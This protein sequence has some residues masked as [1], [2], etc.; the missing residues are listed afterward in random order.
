MALGIARLFNIRLTENFNRPYL[1]QTISEFWRRWHMSFSRWILDYIFRPLQISWR[2]KGTWGIAAA[3]FLAFLASGIWHG[4]TWGFLVWG[5]LFGFYMVIEILYLPWRKKLYRKLKIEK[6]WWMRVWRVFLTFNLVCFSWIFF[7]A[8]TF[9]DAIYTAGHLF[10]GVQAFSCAKTVI[11][12]GAYLPVFQ[13]HFQSDQFIN[14]TSEICLN[15]LQGFPDFV[16]KFSSQNLFILL[17]S[18]AMV[19]F[20]PWIGRRLAF[21]RRAVVFRWLSYLGFAL[22]IIFS[23]WVMETPGQTFNEFM[24]FKF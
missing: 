14:R 4:P 1:A 23:I 12:Y 20:L 5:M 10:T 9:S 16:G 21:E 8:N 17:T 18:L 24:Y 15:T 3:L 13:G 7:R 19:T 11:K 22:W 2:H 6:S